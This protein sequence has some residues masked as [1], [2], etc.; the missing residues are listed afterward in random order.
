[1]RKNLL[2][3]LLAF[4]FW[5]ACTFSSFDRF[6]C[7][8]SRSY[9]QHFSLEIFFWYLF[10]RIIDYWGS[11]FTLYLASGAFSLVVF[12][13]Y[14]FSFFLFLFLSVFSLTDTNDSKDSR[15]GRG[16]TYFSSFPFP[17]AHEH[18]FSSSRFLPL[19]FNRS[20]TRLIADETCS[21][22]RF[23]F[24]LHFHWCNCVGVTGFD[25][26]KRH[27]EDLSSYQTITNRKP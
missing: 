18:S 6:L 19:V 21:P 9:F 25:I 13:P 12:Y 20:N 11:I 27:C 3:S 2:N 7:W 4:F 10:S 24:Y 15:E 1:M 26:S 16:N 5:K 14:F 17:P 8:I 22:Q 23:A